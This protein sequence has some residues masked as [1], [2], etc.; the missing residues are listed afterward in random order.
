MRLTR[1][2]LFSFELLHIEIELPALDNVPVESAGLAGARRN[3]SEQMSRVELVGDLL[4]DLAILASASDLCFDV[5]GALG[6]FTSFIR[7]FKLLLVEFDVV[8]LEVPVAEGVSIDEH[9]GVLHKGLRAHE[10]VVCRV[11][12]DIEDACLEGHGLGTP[13][14][15]SVVETEASV[16]EVSS[17]APHENY[18]LGSNTGHGGHASHLELSLLL[19]NWHAAS[20][21][22]SLLAR[23]PRNTHTS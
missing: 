5:A 22:P 3:A 9:D 21:G 6:V 11:V 19:V 7:F 16:F 17:A 2:L 4:V 8:L 12:N 14:E 15:V 10:L 23:V 20:S 1:S 13:G 18:A